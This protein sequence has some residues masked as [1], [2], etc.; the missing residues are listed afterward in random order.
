MFTRRLRSKETIT[1]RWKMGDKAWSHWVQGRGNKPNRDVI[2]E[3]LDQIRKSREAAK[4][5]KERCKAIVQD[6]QSAEPP[7]HDIKIQLPA[8][9]WGEARQ[10]VGSIDGD[11]VLCQNSALLK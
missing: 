11:P 3:G 7:E 6:T 10:D 9:D 4:N 1:L 8:A 2:L 5:M